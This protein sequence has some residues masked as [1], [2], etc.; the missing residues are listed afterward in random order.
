MTGDP[1]AGPSGLKI[2]STGYGVDVQ[3]LSRQVKI[4]EQLTSKRSEVNLRQR[5]S[6]GGN[7]LVFKRILSGNRERCLGYLLGK[8]AQMRLSG[9]GPREGFRYF[10]GQ[11][12]AFPQT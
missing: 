4:G 1:P 11:T 10:C 12:Q 5:H 9:V 7:K 3:N 2:K 8:T 6:S